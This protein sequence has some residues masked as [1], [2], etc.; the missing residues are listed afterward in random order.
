MRFYNEMTRTHVTI[1]TADAIDRIPD[2]ELSPERLTTLPTTE[3][4]ALFNQSAVSMFPPVG[5]SPEIDQSLAS[6]HMAAQQKVAAV[7]GYQLQERLSVTS[8]AATKCIATSKGK[9]F[10][11]WVF[12]N[13]NHVE[14]KGEWGY[15]AQILCGA[16][17]IA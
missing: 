15:P 9:E 14:C 1:T 13:S 16:C 7:Y 10:H 11:F 4:K 17:T 12:G 6:L 3:G 5:F 8:M 2:S